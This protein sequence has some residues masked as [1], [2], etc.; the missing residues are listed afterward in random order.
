MPPKHKVETSAGHLR[1]YVKH[2]CAPEKVSSA[3][4]LCCRIPMCVIFAETRSAH[5]RTTIVRYPCEF[6][7][8][9]EKKRP[10]SLSLS[11]SH[12]LAY[13]LLIRRCTNVPTH[14]QLSPITR[15]PCF[16][17][18]I[19]ARCRFLSLA[20][21]FRASHVVPFSLSASS[22]SLLSLLRTRDAFLM[23]PDSIQ[24]CQT[25]VRAVDEARATW[26]NVAAKRQRR[27][28]G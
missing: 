5:A 18:R 16:F 27:R 10:L 11:L 25:S 24:K 19:R 22:F 17:S 12:T 8:N 2:H 6:I 14:N 15:A 28:R 13:A 23:F 26:T 3:L 20:L 9:G 1:F 7:A 4:T 21:S